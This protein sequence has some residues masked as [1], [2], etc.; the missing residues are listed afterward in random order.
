MREFHPKEIYMWSAVVGLAVG[1]V[2]GLVSGIFCQLPTSRK[3]LEAK[4]LKE[5]AEQNFKLAS[6]RHQAAVV[7]VNEIQEKLKNN[8]STYKHNLAQTFDDSNPLIQK[9]MLK[10]RNAWL[11]NCE[12]CEQALVIFEKMRLAD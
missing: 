4:K 6:E 7:R 2:A 10:E 11:S 1:T 3:L 8:I 5:I 12:K 9:V